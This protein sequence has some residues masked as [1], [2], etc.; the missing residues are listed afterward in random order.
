[1]FVAIAQRQ[2]M[3]NVMMETWLTGMDVQNNVKLRL[4]GLVLVVLLFVYIAE[5]G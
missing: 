1:M 2:Q 4:V 5:M 3:S